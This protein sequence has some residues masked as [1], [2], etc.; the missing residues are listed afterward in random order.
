MQTGRLSF[1]HCFVRLRRSRTSFTILFLLEPLTGFYSLWFFIEL[2]SLFINVK[3]RSLRC[4]GVT[5]VNEGC[6]FCFG[7]SIIVNNIVH[8]CFVM[9]FHTL[10]SARRA[11]PLLQPQPMRGNL[12]KH[13]CAYTFMTAN[14]YWQDWLV[15]VKR[16]ILALP[17]YLESVSVIPPLWQCSAFLGSLKQNPKRKEVMLQ[18]RA[19]RRV[20]TGQAL[21]RSLPTEGSRIKK[22]FNLK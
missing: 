18:R 14:Q 20:E 1:R 13:R 10:L 12:N 4:A 2:G 8:L 17:L 22:S 9:V 3:H 5:T 6:F 21:N 16:N 11:I 19:G 7:S 15:K